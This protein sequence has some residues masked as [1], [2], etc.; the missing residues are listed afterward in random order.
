MAN[1]EFP[2]ITFDQ[3]LSSCLAAMDA[4]TNMD[5]QLLFYDTPRSGTDVTAKPTSTRQ[6]S[7]V[8]A[9]FELDPSLEIT[10]NIQDLISKEGILFPD[11]LEDTS[12]VTEPIVTAEHDIIKCVEASPAQPEPMPEVPNIS[13]CQVSENQAS[14]VIV[15]SPEELS[16][17]GFTLGLGGIVKSEEN[18]HVEVGLPQSSFEASAPE[19]TITSTSSGKYSHKNTLKAEAPS[20]SI[21]RRS[22]A[23]NKD[24]EEYKQRRERNNVAVRKSRDKAKHRQKETE[25]RVG[26]LTQENERLQKKVDLLTK[27]LTVLKGLFTNVGAALPQKLA[28]LLK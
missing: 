3:D 25:G 28:M 9:D 2:V 22:R 15:L 13:N 24:S 21:S 23:Y 4:D 5:S 16:S 1:N 17:L 18:A 7:F 27:E 26:V 14:E 6:D 19:E 10:Q 12:T 11:L 20:K 8:F